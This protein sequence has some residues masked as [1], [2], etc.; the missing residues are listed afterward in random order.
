MHFMLDI[1]IGYNQSLIQQAWVELLFY[2]ILLNPEL[3]DIWSLFQ[4]CTSWH[5][6]FPYKVTEYKLIT[7]VNQSEQ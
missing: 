7:K 2:Q 5:N 1:R 6:V 4:L 3:L